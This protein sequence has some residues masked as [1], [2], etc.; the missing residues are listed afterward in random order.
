MLASSDAAATAVDCSVVDEAVWDSDR[1]DISISVGAL[2]TVSTTVLMSYS[3]VSAI[4]TNC[5]ATLQASIE[6]K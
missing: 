6:P 1:A 4:F 5:V 2:A 3:K